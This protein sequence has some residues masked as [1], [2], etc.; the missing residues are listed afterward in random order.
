[1]VFS[2]GNFPFCFLICFLLLLVP[3]ALSAHAI[4][5]LSK[6]SRTDVGLI[7]LKL[8][9][10]HI[11]PLGIDHILFVLSLFFLNSKCFRRHKD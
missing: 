10:T 11:I 6:F 4:A 3:Q 8:G 5:D 2:K 7:Y 9:F 1:M